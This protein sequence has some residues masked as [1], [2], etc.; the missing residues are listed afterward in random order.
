[1]NSPSRVKASDRT[2][3]PKRLGLFAS[4]GRAW[5]R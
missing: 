5:L 4:G 3:L 1:M 2:A